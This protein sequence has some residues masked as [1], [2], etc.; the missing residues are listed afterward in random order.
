[1]NKDNFCK[2]QILFTSKSKRSLVSVRPSSKDC[3]R[4]A[5]GLAKVALHRVHTQ[6]NEIQRTSSS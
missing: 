5:L 1:M 2:E 6:K 3:H 4:L